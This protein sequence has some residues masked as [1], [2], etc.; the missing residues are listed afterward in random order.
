MGGFRAR[1][2]AGLPGTDDTGPFPPLAQLSRIVSPDET[3]TE[4]PAA[5]I[6]LIDDDRMLCALLKHWLASEGYRVLLSH[7]G[8]DA[9]A[10]F[11]RERPSLVY[12]D[13][14]LP[15]RTGLETLHALNEIAPTTPIIMLS[16]DDAVPSVVEA[17]RSG[18]LDYLAK[19][20]TRDALIERT[21]EVLRRCSTIAPS[22]PRPGTAAAVAS[23][24]A[25]RGAEPLA[26]LERQAILAAMERFDGNLS[27]VS[28]ALGIGRTTL[29]RK[30]EKFGLR[31]R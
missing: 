21:R 16:A 8:D 26:E 25:P 6:L 27:A 13:V 17:M 2:C 31:D 24:P 22:D 12:L 5:T 14:H 30:L 7:R 28:R 11:D 29:Y 18:A 10:L 23:A 1:T 19:P 20:L 9:E 4:P 15:G 3:P